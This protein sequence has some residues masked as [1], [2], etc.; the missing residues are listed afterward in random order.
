[1]RRSGTPAPA[2]SSIAGSLDRP[3]RNCW[4][5]GCGTQAALL[6]LEEA[7]RDA[8]L[9][10]LATSTSRFTNLPPLTWCSTCS[11]RMRST[12]AADRTANAGVTP[13][14]QLTPSMEDRD[15]AVMRWKTW[16]TRMEGLVSKGLD[17]PYG[18]GRRGWLKCRNRF[19]TAALVGAVT[20]ATPAWNLTVRRRSEI[21]SNRQP[22]DHPWCATLRAPHWQAPWAARV[23]AARPRRTFDRRRDR[24]GPGLRRA[25]LGHTV[26]FVRVRYDAEPRHVTTETVVR[27]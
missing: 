11:K 23:A 7:T 20:G 16:P 15:E 2:A 25:S 12:G 6:V 4:R 8:L 10:A 1:M 24:A 17:R 27:T 19:T 14:L 3:P 9:M 26:R 21:R 18:P 22:L 13:P 5:G